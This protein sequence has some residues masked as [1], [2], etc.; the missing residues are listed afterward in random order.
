MATPVEMFRKQK[1]MAD[2]RT[3]KDEEI[4]ET[5]SDKE[6]MEMEN[7]GFKRHVKEAPGRS[8]LIKKDNAFD[9]AAKAV[10]S[11][12]KKILENLRP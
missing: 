1:A 5:V 8:K 10:P 12:G 7:A 9:E 2:L 11:Q 4:G 3:P 6:Q